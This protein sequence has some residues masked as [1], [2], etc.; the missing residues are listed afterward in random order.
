M[1]K[2][3]CED[4][5]R[6]FEYKANAFLRPE[7]VKKRISENAKKRNFNAIGIAAHRRKIAKAKGESE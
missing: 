3:I 6:V 7:C 4:C 2:G 5:E 1:Y